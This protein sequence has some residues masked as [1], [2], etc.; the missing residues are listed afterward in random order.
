LSAAKISDGAQTVADATT[1]PVPFERRC[2]RASFIFM[3]QKFD[4]TPLCVALDDFA[5]AIFCGKALNFAGNRLGG[6]RSSAQ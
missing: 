3:R 4:A 2:A 5:E 1:K 6:R